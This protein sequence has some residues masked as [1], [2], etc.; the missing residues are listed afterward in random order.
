MRFRISAILLLLLAAGALDFRQTSGDRGYQAQRDR[1]AALFNQGKRLRALLLLEELVK[2][3][4]KDDEMLV[5]LAACLVNH[6]ATWSDA[7]GVFGCR[8][9]WDLS[10]RRRQTPL[11]PSAISGFWKVLL[12]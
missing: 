9:R 5:A 10:A 3:N 12:T 4:P 11:F 6:S 2:P 8:E 7:A 1:A